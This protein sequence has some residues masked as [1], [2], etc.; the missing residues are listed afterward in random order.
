MAHR[1]DQINRATICDVDPEANGPLIGDQ[2]VTTVEAFVRRHV[3]VDYADTVSMHLLGSYER[4]LAESMRRA[5][6]AVNAVEPREH[7]CLVV[8][9]VKTGDTQCETMNDAVQRAERREL[10]SR[11]LTCVHLLE[12]VRDEVL[13]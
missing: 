4:R 8:R 6:F 13:V 9:Y 3:V 5:Y 10:F 1:I 12:V 7:L 11:K 2:S